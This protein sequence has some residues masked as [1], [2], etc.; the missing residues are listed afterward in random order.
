MMNSFVICTFPVIILG[1]LIMNG[2]VREIH[3]IHKIN[4][5]C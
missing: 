2:E 1:L 3:S 4:G 5:E